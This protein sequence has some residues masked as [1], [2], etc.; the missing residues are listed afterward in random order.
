MGVA[1]PSVCIARLAA[2]SIA[3]STL[4]LMIEFFFC[5]RFSFLICTLPA[6]KQRLCVCHYRVYIGKFD[7]RI[8]SQQCRIAFAELF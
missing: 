5:Q 1:D 3:S 4:V 6:R 7:C 2:I 8:I